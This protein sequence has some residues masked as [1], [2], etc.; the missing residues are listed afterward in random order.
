[1]MS[2]FCSWWRRASVSWWLSNS[3]S[4][5]FVIIKMPSQW[6]ATACLSFGVSYLLSPTRFTYVTSALQL[7]SMSNTAGALT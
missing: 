1:M 3:Q 6:V 4:I 2:I 7:S 5:L